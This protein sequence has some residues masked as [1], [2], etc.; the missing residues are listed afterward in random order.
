MH[1][2]WL[3]KPQ[4]L[5]AVPCL[6]T[7]HNAALILPDETLTENTKTYE[8]TPHH[9]LL[10]AI[11]VGL[12]NMTLEGLTSRIGKPGYTKWMSVRGVG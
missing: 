2:C 9:F 7:R 6:R 11:F 10:M 8:H 12:M 4:E 3:E 5:E 1:G